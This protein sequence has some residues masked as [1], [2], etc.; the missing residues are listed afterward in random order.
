[1][2][3]MR[4]IPLAVAVCLFAVVS[5]GQTKKKIDRYK[6]PE[7]PDLKIRSDTPD[8]IRKELERGKKWA[9]TAYARTE[10]P[11]MILSYVCAENR[12]ETNSGRASVG[13]VCGGMV[14]LMLADGR[15]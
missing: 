7:L 4:T 15:I 6:P 13:Q 2:P 8:D 5:V 14:D 1:M 9:Q 3:G 10:V 11:P 12:R